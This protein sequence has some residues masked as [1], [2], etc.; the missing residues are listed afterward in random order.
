MAPTGKILAVMSEWGYW[1]IELVGPLLKLEAAGYS[2][3]FVT[4]RGKR[5]PVLRPSIDTSYMDPPLGVCVTT[6]E[7]SALVRAFEATNR[8]DGTKNLSELFPERPYFCV[9][10][11][12]RKFEAYFEARKQAQAAALAAYDSILLVGGSGPI[13]D[14]VNN[15]RA[16]DLV[17]GFYAAG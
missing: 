11:F 5:S 16:H 15:Q 6:P 4:P 13:V 12:L 8:L 14:V 17:L 9:D 10:P 2:F 7:D 3:D 1:G